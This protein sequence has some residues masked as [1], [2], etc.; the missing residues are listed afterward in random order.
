MA[1]SCLGVYREQMY[2]TLFSVLTLV[3]LRWWGRAA[4]RSGGSGALISLGHSLR[5]AW[6]APSLPD[7]I[8]SEH[9]GSSAR[10]ARAAP[11]PV[12]GW[13]LYLVLDRQAWGGVLYNS[14]V[15]LDRS[16]EHAGGNHVGRLV[17]LP[18]A[19][20]CQRRAGRG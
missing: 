16:W 14:L 1:G 15:C 19:G 4:L 3:G 12:D 7:T 5:A 8:V 9:K 2:G 20:H 11:C 17:L 10:G 13:T 18:A 6:A